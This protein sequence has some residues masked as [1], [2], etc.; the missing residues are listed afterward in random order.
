[1]TSWRK[2]ASMALSPLVALKVFRYTK[3]VDAEND[4]LIKLQESIIRDIT[5]TKEGEAAKID[6]GTSEWDEYVE[7]FTPAVDAEAELE[8][9]DLS[10]D[11]VLGA[12][13]GKDDVLTVADIAALEP[14]F[15]SE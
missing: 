10:L 2:L 7:R 9:F 15:R 1:M 14:F 8:P 5:E 13:G 12:A 3:L 6:P 4:A 11:E